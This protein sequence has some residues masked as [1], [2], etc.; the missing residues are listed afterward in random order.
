MGRECG[1]TN[2]TTK[3]GKVKR[4]VSI[5]DVMDFSFC[6]K[7]FD[8]R[9]N[10]ERTLMHEYNNAIERSYFKYIEELIQAPDKISNAFERLKTSWGN[11]WIKEKDFRSIQIMPTNPNFDTYSLKRRAGIYSITNFY[12]LMK[13]D[14][15][16]PIAVNKSYT[17]N[18]YDNVFITGSW[19]YIREVSASPKNKIQIVKFLKEENRRCAIIQDRN[20]LD[21]IAMCYAF[22]KYFGVDYEIIIF[23]THCKAP[24]QYSIIPRTQKDYDLLINSVKSYIYCIDNNISLM[25]PSQICGICEYKN[26]CFIK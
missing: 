20:D 3:T 9:K 17:V 12:S 16:F 8:H 10:N 23:D 2:T 5:Q 7:F 6:P 24:R 13:R 19:D 14:T 25:S 21:I 22:D 1:I 18:L 4:T 11:E 26:K 15:Q